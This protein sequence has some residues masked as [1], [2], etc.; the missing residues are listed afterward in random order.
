MSFFIDTRRQRI[1]RLI[2][3]RRLKNTS[4]SLISNDC[5]GA[6]VYKHFNL[7]FNTPFIGLML[8]APCFVKL[9]R[10][11]QHYLAQPLQ[12]QTESRYTTINELR[13]RMDHYVPLATLG[14]DVEITFLHY[15]S[16]E[17]AREKWTKRVKR[18]NWNN[19]FFKFDGGKD[20]STPELVQ[21]FDQI[22]FPHLTLL[23]EPQPGIKS[24]VVVPHYVADGLQQFA[25]TLPHIDLAGWLNGGDVHPGTAT[26][27]YN[28]VFFPIIFPGK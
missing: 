19:V 8:Q 20:F 3:R 14:D 28:R 7:P 23:R 27:L 5:W 17:E 16:N 1:G 2:D 26:S 24:A 21:A 13:S 9:A 25:R 12:F 15:H 11:P 18:I 4:F 22:Q 6:E 10:N